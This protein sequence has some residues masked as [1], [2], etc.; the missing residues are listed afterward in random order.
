MRLKSLYILLVISMILLP[1]VYAD[2]FF[3][4]NDHLGSPR[5][6][7]DGKG[8]VEWSTDYLP[9]GSELRE[10]GDGDYKY[11]QK[12]HDDS[13]LFYYGA[14]FYDPLIGRFIT[15]DTVQ[16]LPNPYAYVSNNPMM[17]IDWISTSGGI[18][19]KDSTTIFDNTDSIS[20]LK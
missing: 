9:F 10:E 1:C 11:N 7:T 13:G 6:V 4:H 20:F 2:I 18:S 19:A 12:E 17:A 3:Y 14:R 16:T 15:P 5:V 8:F